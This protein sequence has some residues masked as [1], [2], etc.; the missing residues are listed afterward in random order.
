LGLR[1]T[2]VV[3]GKRGGASEREEGLAG[4]RSKTGL[5]FEGFHV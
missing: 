1:A 2:E 3:V 4:G 5:G